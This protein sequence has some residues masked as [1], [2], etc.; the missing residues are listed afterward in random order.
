MTPAA[1]DDEDV[2]A[3]SDAAWLTET[4]AL[5]EDADRADEDAEDDDETAGDDAAEDDTGD[6]DAH[7]RPGQ[8]GMSDHTT[9]SEGETAAD[10]RVEETGVL[11]AAAPTS[12]TS[13]SKKPR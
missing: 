11:P 4:T 8:D 9:T 2:Y 6:S 7:H 5:D 3:T 1:G 10:E 12:T 13:T